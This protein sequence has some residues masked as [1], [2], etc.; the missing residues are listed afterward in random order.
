MLRTVSTIALVA[1]MSG[2]AFATTTTCSKEPASKFASKTHLIDILHK[3]GLTVHRIKTEN[4]CY[5][6]YASKA[7]GSKIN[8]AVNAVTLHRTKNP[9]AGEN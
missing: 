9:E 2:S 7:D 3:E 6:I 5:E 1:V 4:G 8:I